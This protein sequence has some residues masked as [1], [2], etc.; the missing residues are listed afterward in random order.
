MRAQ[1]AEH[2]AA[3]DPE[4]P[5]PDRLRSLEIAA[6][7][8]TSG[9]SLPEVLDR[10]IAGVADAVPAVRHVL[11]IGLPSGGKHSRWRGDSEA[12]AEALLGVRRG[13]VARHSGADVLAVPVAS[14]TRSYG[15]PLALVPHD[16]HFSSVDPTMLA[17]HGH[18][19]AAGIEMTILLSELGEQRETAE[20]LLEAGRAHSE[21][22]TVDDVAQSISGD[23]WGMATQTSAKWH[24]AGFPVETAVNVS[25]AQLS[26]PDFLSQVKGTLHQTGFPATSLTIEITE[27]QVL[28][29]HALLGTV[30]REL[31]ELGA[32]LSIDDFG[33][34]FFSL[35]QVQRMPVTKVKIDRSFTT[36]SHSSDV[37][38]FLS[39]IVALSHGLPL[40][41]TA[42]GVET[43]EQLAAVR[44]AGC[45][46]AQGNLLGRPDAAAANLC[47]LKEAA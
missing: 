30:L 39:G 35:N 9:G 32:G 28:T 31:R 24:A 15:T 4:G 38:P 25:V 1:A 27:S 14:G 42:E 44:V 8:L 34:G 10:V 29:H 22:D 36:E 33:T 3:N 37:S 13:D 26:T 41:V 7:D 40:R 6:R 23:F 20:M 12:A 17:G 47:L 43:E 11:C 45:D 21:Q 19:A 18:H 16:A 46:R 5:E 2:P